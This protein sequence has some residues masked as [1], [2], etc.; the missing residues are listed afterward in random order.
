MELDINIVLNM[1]LEKVVELEKE[2]IYSRAIN[3][4][5]M[6][7]IDELTK[8]LEAEEKEENNE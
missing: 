3:Q 7:K 6:Q 8:L 5:L 4:Q 2:L 1:A